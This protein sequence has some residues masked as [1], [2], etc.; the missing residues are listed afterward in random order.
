MCFSDTHLRSKREPICWDAKCL[1]PQCSSRPIPAWC[2]S[3]VSTT[4]PAQYVVLTSP[5]I[6]R[7]TLGWSTWAN[8]S[9]GTGGTLDHRL[10]TPSW[11]SN[12]TTLYIFLQTDLRR[13]PHRVITPLYYLT[14]SSQRQR[15]NSL[16]PF[17]RSS[18]FTFLVIGL[19]MRSSFS[20]RNV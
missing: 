12:P 1:V 6:L 4:K 9:P 18:F 17:S 5:C 19:I 14:P 10:S 11:S 7:L 3:M 2:L 20:V 15:P 16:L 13:N 8:G